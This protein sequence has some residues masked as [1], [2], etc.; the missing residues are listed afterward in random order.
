MISNQLCS[1]CKTQASSSAACIFKTMKNK[2][3]ASVMSFL[4]GWIRKNVHGHNPRNY[5]KHKCWEKEGRRACHSSALLKKLVMCMHDW[6]CQSPHMLI[7]TDAPSSV[8]LPGKQVRY[9]YLQLKSPE[10]SSGPRSARLDFHCML[11][12][13]SGLRK[14][15]YKTVFGAGRTTGNSIWKSRLAT[16]PKG[17]TLSFLFNSGN[18]Q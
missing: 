5:S 7:T 8:H 17:L 15:L 14:S 4:M 11:L 13:I 1:L 3:P 18:S 2:P 12:T 10:C 9:S 16:L 6:E